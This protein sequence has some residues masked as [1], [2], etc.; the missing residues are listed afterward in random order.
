[1]SQQFH[2]L[3]H[4]HSTSMK[5]NW[6]RS[7][8]TPASP[9]KEGWVSLIGRLANVLSLFNSS[10]PGHCEYLSRL[11]TGR[12]PGCLREIVLFAEGTACKIKSVG[13]EAATLITPILTV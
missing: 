1:M 12:H 4:L 9:P 13:L 2:F 11:G 5:L 7:F 10:K 3:F 6:G 8:F